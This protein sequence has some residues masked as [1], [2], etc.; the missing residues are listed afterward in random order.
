VNGRAV[1]VAADDSLNAIRDKINA[2]NSG[3]NASGV[4]AT[5][6]TTGPGAHRLILT[7]DQTGSRGIELVDSASGGGVL[8]DLGILDGALVANTAPG[9]ASR[10]ESLRVSSTATALAGMLGVSPTP[11]LTSIKVDGRK[12][13]VDLANDTMID[14][15]NR[16]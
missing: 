3:S 4:T 16:V 9:D 15:M 13:D 7:A 5:I 6:L 12:I 8:R 10:T 11:A 1:D 2:V 14:V